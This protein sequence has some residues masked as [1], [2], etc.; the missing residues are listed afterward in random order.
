MGQVGKDSTNSKR[1]PP[2][3]LELQKLVAL[4]RDAVPAAVDVEPQLWAVRRRLTGAQI[5]A[6]VAKYQSGVG[7]PRLCDEYGTSK[8]SML[9]LLHERGVGM[10]RQPLTKTQ[11]A[12]AARL[13]EE[14]RAI[15][16]IAD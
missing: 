3:L 12:E 4:S 13:D 8:P 11:R 2:P 7:A 15:K 1:L 6:I 10:R 16:P 14:G 9:E 5:D